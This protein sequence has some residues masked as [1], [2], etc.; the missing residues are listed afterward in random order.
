MNCR[1]SLNHLLGGGQQRLLDGEAEEFGGLEV[2]DYTLR[3]THPM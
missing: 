2:D 3:S 1:L